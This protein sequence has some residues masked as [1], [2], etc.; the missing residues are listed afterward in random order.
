MIRP[1]EARCQVEKDFQARQTA[2]MSNA[3]PMVNNRPRAGT[4]M[5]G[6]R[7]LLARMRRRIVALVGAIFNS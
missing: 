7:R 1:S 3:A 6:R 5:R 4:T 2:Y